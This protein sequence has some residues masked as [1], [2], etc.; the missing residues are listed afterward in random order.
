MRIKNIISAIIIAGWAS[1]AVAEDAIKPWKGE[2]ELG[3]V[4]TSGNTEIQSTKARAG[5][6]NEREEWRHTGKIEALNTSD[7]TRTTAERY[8]LSGK[9]DYKFGNFDYA[10]VMVNYE[11][12]RFTGYSYRVSETVGYGHRIVNQPDLTLGLEIGPGARQSK[13]S[14]GASESEFIVRVA[15]NAEW[16]I[17]ETA[18][19]TENLSA[20]SGELSTLTRSVTALSAQLVGAFA[21]KLSF[22]AQ[23]TSRVP[24]SVKKLDTVT[25]VT[26]VYGF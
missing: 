20:E 2:A 1:Q 16:K 22:T 24:V 10:L 7:A 4:S 8:L 25:A 12:D 6:V 9:S 26:L 15:G 3:I 21:M 5:I 19:F 13:L 14:T 23:H 17:S 18:V 11:N